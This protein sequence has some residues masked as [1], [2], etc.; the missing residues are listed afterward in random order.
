M[1]ASNKHWEVLTSPLKRHELE[2][3]IRHPISS[4]VIVKAA[5][6]YCGIES[7]VTLTEIRED[8]NRCECRKQ[9]RQR[10]LN[11]L[12]IE[13]KTKT[14]EQWSLETSINLNSIRTRYAARARGGS[15]ASAWSDSAILFGAREVKLRE[16]LATPYTGLTLRNFAVS[17]ERLLAE[18]VANRLDKAKQLGEVCEVTK[19]TGKIAGYNFPIVDI[20]M[21]GE[22]GSTLGILLETG[23]SMEFILE[24][25][26]KQVFTSIEDKLSKLIHMICKVDDVSLTLQAFEIQQLFSIL[27]KSAWED[28]S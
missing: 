12:T 22:E 13:G 20:D 2:R 18:E 17:V 24:E 6:K 28:E 21:F 23:Y 7:Y 10:K 15:E 11:T 9:K 1:T 16:L 4:G 27:E 5:C 26:K 14:L 25:L 8:R 3:N 19:Y